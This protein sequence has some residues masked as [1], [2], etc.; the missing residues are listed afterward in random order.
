MF[1]TIAPTY[2]LLNTLLSLG[3]DA[4][5]RQ[6]AV[7]VARPHPEARVLDLCTGTA[8]LA[9]TF[10]RRL[11]P[12]GYVVASDFCWEML[13]LARPK[14]GGSAVPVALL[15]AD[16]LHLPFP[17]NSFDV[18]SAA[19]GIRNVSNLTTGLK[20][21]ARVIKPGGKVVILEFSLPEG[22]IFS[23]LYNFYFNKLLPWLGNSIAPGRLKAYSYL[24][25]SV[26]RFAK[27]EELK[28][29]MESCGLTEVE[30][31]PLT[32]GIVTLYTGKKTPQ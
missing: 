27:A 5:W 30:S 32:L 16:A 12:G 14:L 9:L 22:P 24:P 31:Y 15:Q 29:E 25:A 20:E 18:A 19:F 11:G 13:A 2:D 8:E 17:D 4:R 26:G 23:R 28:R 6:K 1:A 7:E 10:A 3:F 21:M